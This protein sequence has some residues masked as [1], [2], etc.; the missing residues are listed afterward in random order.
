MNTI[1]VSEFEKEMAEIE[2]LQE[3]VSDWINSKSFFVRVFN[4]G[5]GRT[6]RIH[7]EAGKRMKLLFSKELVEG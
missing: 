3:Q 1:T 5:I 6:Q 7:N 4:F 2:K